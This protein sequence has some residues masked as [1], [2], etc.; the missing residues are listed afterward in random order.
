MGRSWVV[1]TNTTSPCCRSSATNGSDSRRSEQKARV[2]RRPGNIARY[3]HATSGQ[4]SRYR[5][6]SLLLT[7]TRSNGGMQG[8]QAGSRGAAGLNL[9]VDGGGREGGGVEVMGPGGAGQVDRR[10]V[11]LAEIHEPRGAP[12]VR[13]VVHHQLCGDP[14]F[15]A[16]ST[17]DGE[18]RPSHAVA[19]IGIEGGEVVLGQAPPD[20]RP[21]LRVGDVVLEE[22]RLQATVHRHGVPAVL[23]AEAVDV[24]AL[25]E[26]RVAEQDEAVARGDALEQSL[27]REE[28]GLVGADPHEHS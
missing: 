24:A 4:K 12:Q 14:E 9:Q 22:D 10:A 21:V 11:E 13:G 26:L 15:G 17:Q 27:V 19:D 1:G 7:I 16:A 6:S 3:V 28:V 20:G 25:L 2:T 5:G 18:V 23:V 8:L